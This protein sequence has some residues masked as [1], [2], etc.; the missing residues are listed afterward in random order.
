MEE[1]YEMPSSGQDAAILIMNSQ[2]LWFPAWASIRLTMSTGSHGL[3]RGSW[4]LF[5]AEL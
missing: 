3:G 5:P 4:S 2:H 1:D